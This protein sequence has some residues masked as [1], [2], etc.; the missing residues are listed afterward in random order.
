MSRIRVCLAVI[1]C[2]LAGI[3]PNAA[4]ASEEKPWSL[5]N[6]YAFTVGQGRFEY[7][8]ATARWRV[9][10]N[11]GDAAREC[12]LAD[13]VRFALTLDD[14]R[15]ITSAN[16]E[17]GVANRERYNGLFGEGSR[18][19]VQFAPSHGLRVTHQVTAFRASPFVLLTLL[20]ENVSGAPLTI[21]DLS[22]VLAMPGCLAHWPAAAPVK[23]RRQA[24]WAGYSERSADHSSVLTMFPDPDRGA[25]LAIGVLPEGRALACADFRG[26]GGTWEGAVQCAY[27]PPLRLAPGAAL[28]SEPAWICY[29]VP[30]PALVD[31]HY[32]WALGQVPRPFP[33]ATPPQEWITVREGSDCAALL[34]QAKAWRAAGVGYALVPGDWESAPGSLRGAAPRYPENMADVVKEFRAL[35][36]TPG[37]SV[38]PLAFS[39]SASGT[40]V[41]TGKKTKKELP[42]EPNAVSWINPAAEDAL[43]KLTA[44]LNTIRAW[45]F[46]FLV[47]VPSAIPDDT[48]QAY[49]LTRIEADRR[50]FEL[51]SAAAANLPALPAPAA[52]LPAQLDPWLEASA[53]GCS[54]AQYSIYP[55]PLRLDAEG[56][57]GF[58]VTLAAAMRFWPGSIELLGAPSANGLREA[59]RLT[60][61]PRVIARPVDA[62][63]DAPHLW[64]ITAK[65]GGGVCLGGAMVAFPGAASWSLDQVEMDPNAPL[66]VWRPSDGQPIDARAN[67]LP[68]AVEFVV[69]GLAPVANTPLLIGTSTGLALH[70]DHVK[71]LDWNAAQGVLRGCIEA[72]LE[73]TATA[74]IAIPPAWEYKSGELNGKKLK[75]KS[76]AGLLSLPLED[77]GACFELTFREAG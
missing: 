62:A 29:G 55:A 14:G 59:S 21:R 46:G 45:G 68:P 67:P 64:Q 71:S 70:L 37:L 24:L 75:A 65:T 66:V 44:R 63:Q 50:G 2:L 74:Y 8:E 4:A 11:A 9:L 38:D 61:Q 25:C 20:V 73:A 54:M 34:N 57:Q 48:L 26:S 27:T 10:L 39:G 7:D 16:L 72:P 60:L 23:M 56:L 28:V 22:P 43:E 58:D 35:R 42:G 49:G 3:C 32:S 12:T 53:G 40:A 13:E 47:S 51:L 6:C 1:G 15:V 41:Q 77:T 31:A 19:S 52:T 33:K 36:V 69:H 18:Y 30:D 76:N 5:R 17:K